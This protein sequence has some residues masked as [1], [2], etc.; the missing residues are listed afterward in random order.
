MTKWQWYTNPKTNY[1]YRTRPD[2]WLLYN[3]I[4]QDGG[5]G[6][7][8]QLQDFVRDYFKDR[9]ASLAL[10]VGAN[11]GIT[12]I[13][14]ANIFDKV[15]AFEPI[16]DVFKQL[17]MVIER[18]G[19]SNVEIKQMAIG[20]TIGQVRMRYRPNNSFASSVNDKGDQEV[21]ITTLDALEYE[22][23][24]FIKIDVEGLETE[25]IAGAWHTIESQ[26][27]MIQFEYKPNLAK[28]FK[29][30]I[31]TLICARLETLNYHIQD[32]RGLPYKESRQK[33]MFAIPGKI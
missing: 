17:E 11:M 14:Y 18:N 1:H 29:H 10:D 7:Q 2:D 3:R 32:K 6:Y 12:A 27:P 26:R 24:D 4:G 13:E 15:V 28:R 16:E 20:N 19:L 22:Q 33:D 23:V 31:D 8:V 9:T 5:R 21:A 25:V 30:D